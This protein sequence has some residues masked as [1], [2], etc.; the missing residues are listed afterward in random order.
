MQIVLPYVIPN[1]LQ[2]KRAVD[3]IGL[4]IRPVGEQCSNIIFR[5]ILCGHDAVYI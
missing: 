1:I 3:K 2:R 5:H 4:Y